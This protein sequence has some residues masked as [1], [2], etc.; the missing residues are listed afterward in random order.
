M[1]KPFECNA[2]A[3]DQEESSS[4]QPVAQE[5]ALW[6]APATQG[7]PAEAQAPSMWFCALCG[8]EC[9]SS[10]T[11]AAY[12]LTL[13]VQDAHVGSSTSVQDTHM[14]SSTSVQ[15]AHVGS[16]TAGGSPQQP[17]DVAVDPEAAVHLL[18]VPASSFAAWVPAKRA[19]CWERVRGCTLLASLY[20]GGGPFDGQ[21]SARL[22]VAGVRQLQPE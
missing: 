19:E 11:T 17:A 20:V 7:T 22:C 8:A 21:S 14:G 5:P 10:A 12:R 1:H 9:R 6:P 4:Q 15:D 18:G 13:P 3:Q 2:C 16:G